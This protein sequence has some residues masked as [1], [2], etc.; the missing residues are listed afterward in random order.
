MMPHSSQSILLVDDE[1]GIRK[2][3]GIYLADMGYTVHTAHDTESALDIFS[4]L[5]PPIVLTDI[6]MPG[7]DGM[8][9]L[10]KIKQINPE[11]EVIMITGHGDMDLAIRSL[12]LDATDFVTKPIRHDALEIALRRAQER[13]TMRDQLRNYTENLERLVAEKTQKLIA[14]ER[15][16][17]IGQTIA[18]LS[19][20]IK[21]IAGG[22]KGGGFVLEKGL[23]LDNREYLV[24]GWDMV[25]GNVEKITHLS[26]DL[27]NYAKAADI[28]YAYCDPNQLVRDVVRLMASQAAEAG[29]TLEM[30]PDAGLPSFFMDSDGIQQCLLNLV[31]NAIDACEAVE[32]K[33]PEKTVTIRSLRDSRSV[34]AF[35]VTDTGIGMDEAVQAKLFQGFFSTKGTRGTGIGLMIT[36]K[37]V[38]LHGGDIEVSSLVNAG[39][40]VTI[41]IPVRKTMPE[42]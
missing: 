15:M 37:I 16:A 14:S 4:K 40:T 5:T 11:T 42:K 34:V 28:T 22:L 27:L 20:T 21:N 23:S 1:A 26:I 24:Q 39:S 33:N 38:D 29:V 13:I 41:Q 3:L 32:A 10:Q 8:V 6:K 2:V 25:K 9:L 35:Q 30:E 36:Q 31:T 17:A 19:H 7:S 12:K 18:G